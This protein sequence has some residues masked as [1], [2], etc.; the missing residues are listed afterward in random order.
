MA[1]KTLGI[2]IGEKNLKA[3]LLLR[4][5]R[6]G[7]KVAEAITVNISEAGGL[8]CAMES[9]LQGMDL[10]QVRINLSLPSRLV[11]FHNVKL[12]FREEKKIKQTIAFELE[13]LLPHGIDDYFLDFHIVHQDR[14][15]EILA[16]VAPRNIVKERIALFGDNA[17]AIGM[18]GID[19]LPVVSRLLANRVIPGPGL[20][21]DVGARD[22]VAV[23]VEDSKIIC[24]RH[25]AFGGDFLL[26]S[27]DADMRSLPGSETD[28]EVKPSGGFDAVGEAC[29]SFCR[30]LENTIEIVKWGG[31]MEDGPAWVF[32]TGGG[33]FDHRFREELSRSFTCPIETADVAAMDK[34]LLPDEIKAAWQPA[35]MN[36]ALALAIDGHKKGQGVS[37]SLR[38]M[39]TKAGREEFGKALRWGAAVFSLAAL[40]LII[41]GYMDY[42]YS[43]LRLDNLKMEIS[44]VFKGAAPDVVRIVDPVQ[45][46]KAKIAETRKISAGLGGLEGGGAV[47]DILKDI[48]TFAPASTEF[49]ITAF[50]L[51]DNRV[52][53]KGTAKNFDAVDTLKRELAKSKYLTS[54]QI[55]ATSLIKQGDKVEFDLRMTAQR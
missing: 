30:E 41:D 24:I 50:N 20:L 9:L 40:L 31:R 11:S 42:R 15:T 55:G 36:Q 8:S 25:Y 46:F 23:F 39:E 18:I 22:T 33:T 28:C 3:V 17:A 34:V 38:E 44:A 54:V 14:H 13:T 32:L 26:P 29:R 53:I 19:A 51:D 47:L 2:D 45:Q 1:D 7:L 21:L 12:P 16:A 35:L 52:S 43:R 48:S 5:M 27:V 49:Q 4:G 6:S 37:F 10:A